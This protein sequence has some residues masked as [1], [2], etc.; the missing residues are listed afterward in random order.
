MSPDLFHP[1]T[2]VRIFGTPYEVGLALGQ[3]GR[4]IVHRHLTSSPAWHEVL[5]RRTDP[6]VAVMAE[7]LRSGFPRYWAELEGLAEGLQ[8]P[9]EDV[10]LWNCR[11]DLRAMAPDGC[12]TIQV[13]AT[14]RLVAHNED[15]DPGFRG[16]CM[17]AFIDSE[18]GRPFAAFAYPA[19][20]PGHAFSLNAAGL[21]QAVNNVRPLDGDAGL[22][23]MALARAALDCGS[24]D[25]V[26]AMLRTRPSAGGFHLTLAS[27]GEPDIVSVEFTSSGVSEL[28][29]QVP[30]LHANHLVHDW[31]AVAQTIT[32]S[33]RARQKRGEQLLR[34]RPAPSPGDCLDILWD[35]QEAELPILRLDP[36]DPDNENTLATALFTISSAS[37]RLAIYDQPHAS[38][39]LVLDDSLF[40]CVGEGRG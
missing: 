32:G 20:I 15:G 8:L 35:R 9:L 39:R 31:P 37:V 25:E 22:P 13:P 2:L 11:G 10:F 17:L 21:V 7:G 3:R 5:Q 28:K 33:S 1:L 14:P 34:E 26:V 19:S 12:T 27:S 24:I 16:H 23:R 36:A 6:R 18:G 38:A 30:G 40:A 29:L 4:G